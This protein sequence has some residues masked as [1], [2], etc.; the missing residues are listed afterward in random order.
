[1]NYDD[2]KK[3]LLATPYPHLVEQILSEPIDK[4]FAF[5]EFDSINEP[6][7]QTNED[8][9]NEIEEIK[10]VYDNEVF[11]Q[12]VKELRS[13]IIDNLIKPFGLAKILFKDRDGGNITTIHNARKDIYADKKD[14]YD[15]NQ[16]KTSQ[17][18]KDE[19][20]NTNRTS[21]GYIDNYTGKEVSEVDVDHH[22]PLKRSH[23]EG[24]FMLNEKQKNEYANDKRNLTTTTPE[25][26]RSKG[27]D[28]MEEWGEKKNSK[29]TE[30]TN[31]EYYEIDE[32]KVNKIKKEAKN[33]KDEHIN[34]KVKTKYYGKEILKKGGIEG[35]KFGFQQAVGLFLKEMIERCL[36][37]TFDAFKSNN[38]KFN[39]IFLNDLRKRL[40]VIGNDM[41]EN[42]KKI[43]NKFIDDF[44]EGTIS[45]LLSTIVTTVIN[46][47]VTTTAKLVRMIREGFLSLLRA[48]KI[49]YMKP[50]G[51]TKLEAMNEASKIIITALGITAGIALEESLEKAIALLPFANLI[52]VTLASIFSGVAIS[53]SIYLFDSMDVF[54]VNNAAKIKYVSDVLDKSIKDNEKRID[55]IFNELD[56][57]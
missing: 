56:I 55:E 27:A 26:N 42:W 38:R 50:N 29:D 18:T 2:I 13:Q 35:I 7:N 17:K 8:F 33:A 28:D 36:D 23:Q 54:G 31:N 4:I 10:K 24:S 5:T 30:K 6:I 32:K 37:E 9:S 16:Y 47:F 22:I 52:S 25:I 1:M 34:A 40:G 14:K 51:M 46:M 53:L 41:M 57:V 44:K 12:R 48:C 49:I 21:G 43:F 3:D 11:N 39:K 45:G 20:K 15:R 19:V